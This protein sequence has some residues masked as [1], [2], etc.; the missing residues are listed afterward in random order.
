MY[1]HIYILRS[2]DINTDMAP[3]KF[4]TLLNIRE[5][6]NSHPERKTDFTQALEL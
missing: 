4:L 2:V 6:S 5:T 1:N 3:L